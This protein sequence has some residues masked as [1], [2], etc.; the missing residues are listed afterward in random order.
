MRGRAI[1]YFR[2]A[3]TVFTIGHRYKLCLVAF[4]SAL[5]LEVACLFMHRPIEST[6]RGQMMMYAAGVSLS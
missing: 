4:L 2:I 6:C 1:L 5:D 3:M